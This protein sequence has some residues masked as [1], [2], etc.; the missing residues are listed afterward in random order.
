MSCSLCN[1]VCSLYVTC[2]TRKIYN[3]NKPKMLEYLRK[4]YHNIK[5]KYLENDIDSVIWI[6][7]RLPKLAGFPLEEDKVRR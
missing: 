4:L 7:N 6:V 2:K 5:N 1:F 3:S